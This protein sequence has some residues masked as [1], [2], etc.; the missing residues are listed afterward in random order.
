MIYVTAGHTQNPKSPNFDPGAV[1]KFGKEADLTV[2]FRNLLVFELQK[3]N[4]IVWIDDDSDSL[5]QVLKKMNTDEHSV[6]LDIHFDSSSNENASGC[7]VY[8]PD[9]HTNDEQYYGMMIAESVSSA[10]GIMNRGVFPESKTHVGRLG[11]MREEGINML[12]ELGYV[13]NKFDIEQYHKNKTI[14]AP[15]IAQILINAH[16]KL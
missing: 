16:S 3:R 14:L 9:R 4:A 13:S 2:D 11:V 12:V 5:S 8:I 1:S 6:C 15:S 7:S 10:L